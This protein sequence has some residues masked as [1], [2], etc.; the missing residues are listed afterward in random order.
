MFARMSIAAVRRPLSTIAP[1][2]AAPAR[3][4]HRIKCATFQNAPNDAK[5]ATLHCTTDMVLRSTPRRGLAYGKESRFGK[6]RTQVLEE[7][8]PSQKSDWLSQQQSAPPA[9][10][11]GATFP[12]Y[13][14]RR[15]EQRQGTQFD[16]LSTGVVEHMRKVYATLAAGIG[17]AAGGSLFA[18]ATPLATMP[19]II[20]GL[21][22][23]VPLLGL[24]YTSKH[25]HSFALRAGL[26]A[27][28]TGLSG[29]ALA[30]LLLLALKVSPAIVPQALI[31]TTALFGSMTALSLLAPRG[32][33]LRWG[34][35]LGGG[36]IVLMGAGIASMFVP[37]TSAWYPLLHGVQMYGGLTL[38]TLYVAYDT[39]KMIDEYEMGE[40]DH[41]KH[42]V[43]LFIDF[44]HIFMRILILLM[45]RSND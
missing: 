38:F 16:A 23:I 35:P 36:V 19:A 26:Y 4:F 14:S 18:M 22:A 25:T 5:G 21:A 3:L 15:D 1:S 39:Q 43:D 10:A 24:M 27:A 37:V 41:L 20:P 44:K 30:P 11:P 45:G 29:V 12:S 31:L 9:G 17:I 33:M 32:A 8:V 2:I 6:K 28:F 40:D 13:G 34:V 7:Q 42:A